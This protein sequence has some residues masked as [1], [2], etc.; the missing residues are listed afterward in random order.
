MQSCYLYVMF[1]YLMATN[2][3][4]M[5]VE[6]LYLHILV[7]KTFSIEFVQTYNYYVI[8]WGMYH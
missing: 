7:V 2:F 4:W 1:T 8:G 6:G 5:F 3:F